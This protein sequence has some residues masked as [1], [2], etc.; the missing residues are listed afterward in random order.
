MIKDLLYSGAQT[1]IWA[2]VETCMKKG[3][4]PLDSNRY[5]G[6]DSDDPVAV[7]AQCKTAKAL[8]VDAFM[9]NSYAEGSYE[10]HSRSVYFTA[11]QE[12]GMNQ[13]INIDGGAFGNSLAGLESYMAY[14]KSCIDKLPN[15]EK[16]KGKP[17]IT[18]FAKAGNNPSWFRTIEQKYPQ[19]VFVYNSSNWGLNQMAWI[20]SDLTA[21]LDWF[22]RTFGLKK[23]GS[24]NIPC[25]FSGFNDNLNGH[26]CW[27]KNS[28]ARIW[29]AEGPNVGTYKACF[30]VINKY[31]SVSNPLEFLQLV[32][33][34][35][36]DEL[37]ALEHG[38][39]KL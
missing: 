9:Y 39:P 2:H 1:R 22:I 14:T 19:Y 33:W 5:P 25:V 23:D 6:Y 21:N 18:Y 7:L 11:T 10:D 3:S 15:Y 29:P 32:T 37:S 38:I 20:Q 24:L 28:P 12:A 30:D 31:Y 35:D 34:N 26:S 27:N 36:W 4:R 16:F 17:I 13:L 8:G